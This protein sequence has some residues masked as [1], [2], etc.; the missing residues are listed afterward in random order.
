MKETEN[1]D[2]TSYTLAIFYTI[3]QDMGDLVG[4]YMQPIFEK[5]IEIDDKNVVKF[6]DVVVEK[7]MA[8]SLISLTKANAKTVKN[9]SNF[10]YFLLKVS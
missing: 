5:C 10:S 8:P 2:K 3:V 7:F 4:P 6:V 9:S 1:E